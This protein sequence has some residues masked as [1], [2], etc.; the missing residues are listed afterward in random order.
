HKVMFNYLL[1]DAC[2][3][4]KHAYFLKRKISIYFVVTSRAFLSYIRHKRGFLLRSIA[5]EMR[6]VR[7]DY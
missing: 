7:K 4:P 5:I 1:G 3:T 6:L 2:H